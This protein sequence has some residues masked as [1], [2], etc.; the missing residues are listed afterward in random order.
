MP[1]HR[2][3]SGQMLKSETCCKCSEDYML[4]GQHNPPRS[5]NS[6]D[7]KEDFPTPLGLRGN[8]G[9]LVSKKLR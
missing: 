1:L 4:C 9:W 6:S 7:F 3:L 2:G 8:L 5:L